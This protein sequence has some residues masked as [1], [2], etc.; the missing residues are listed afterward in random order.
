MKLRMWR[1]RNA[2]TQAQLAQRLNVSP[3]RV[4]RIECGKVRRLSLQDAIAIERVTKG[5]V[6]PRDL[7][8]R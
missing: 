2:L 4:H 7:I 3:Y 6:K 1:E 5:R 8:N